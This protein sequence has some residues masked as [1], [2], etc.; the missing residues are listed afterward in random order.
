MIINKGTRALI[1]FCLLP[2]II[3]ACTREIKKLEVDHNV[4]YLANGGFEELD[5]KGIPTHWF[6]AWLPDLATDLKMET[7][8]T[9]AHTGTT[10]VKISC[11]GLKE[12]VCNN[13]AQEIHDFPKSVRLHLTGWIKTQ[14]V[15]KDDVVICIQCWDKDNQMI[16]FGTTQQKYIFEGTMDWTRVQTDAFVPEDTK[17]ICVRIVLAGKGT[18]W[19]DDISLVSPTQEKQSSASIPGH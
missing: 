9:C 1:L 3:V 2:F 15:K 5:G 11:A 6:R 10:S 17:I 7:D 14:D 4:N 19:F 13:W 16:G 18:V 12:M 8:K